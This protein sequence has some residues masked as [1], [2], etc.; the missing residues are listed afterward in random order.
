MYLSSKLNTFLSEAELL[1]Y[2]IAFI[3]LVWADCNG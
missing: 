3:N 1:I 2:I